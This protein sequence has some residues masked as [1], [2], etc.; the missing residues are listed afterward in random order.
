MIDSVVVHGFETSNNIKVR[1]ALGHKGIPYEFRTIDPADRADV[2]RLSGQFLTPVMVH[3]ER[4]LFDSGA[5]LR[6]LDANFPTTPKLFGKSR[7][8]QWEI[9][10]W[11]RFARGPLAE[12]MLEVVHTRVST[13]SVPPEVTERCAA[14]WAAAAATLAD[15]LSDRPWLAGDAL[16]AADLTAAA[17]LYRVRSAAIF[18][19]P[20][21]LAAVEGWSQGILELDPS[22]A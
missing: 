2:V 8:E 10:D 14:A 7:D 3:G 20:E 12:P 13:G 17:V 4:V 1:L 19:W 18:P 6:Y 15:R 9:E 21:C 5:I 11:E 22:L 16:S